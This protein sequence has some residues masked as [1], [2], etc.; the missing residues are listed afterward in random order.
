MQEREKRV[1]MNSPH[2]VDSTYTD[3]RLDIKTYPRMGH[4]PY[5][6]K[7][8]LGGFNYKYLYPQKQI[9][10][11]LYHRGAQINRSEQNLIS[12]LTT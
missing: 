4:S 6:C 12:K 7:R 2:I 3:M 9:Q 1:Q 10:K 5:A 11:D 8:C